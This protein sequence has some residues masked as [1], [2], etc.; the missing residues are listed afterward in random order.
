MRQYVLTYIHKRW[1]IFLMDMWQKVYELGGTGKLA[2]RLPN[3]T[4][5][6]TSM[7]KTR[8]CVPARSAAAVARV[9]GVAPSEIRPD[10]F[11]PMETEQTQKAA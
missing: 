4:P 3:V 11:P 9:L 10:V 1:C 5:K 6:Q 2:A 8:G 7:W